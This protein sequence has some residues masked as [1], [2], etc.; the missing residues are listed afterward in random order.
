MTRSKE[1]LSWQGL[2]IKLSMLPADS[3][4]RQ[5]SQFQVAA[6]NVWL[7]GHILTIIVSIIMTIYIILD[8]LM[9]KSTCC[10]FKNIE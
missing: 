6:F 4:V 2:Q 9:N 7:I 3:T 8:H 1:F 5:Q 10:I